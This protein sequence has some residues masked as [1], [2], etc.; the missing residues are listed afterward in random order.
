MKP[1]TPIPA[2]ELMRLLS[3]RLE[4]Q[5]NVAVVVRHGKEYLFV[6]YE[7]YDAESAT[8][9]CSAQKQPEVTIQELVNPIVY[10]NA[11]GA[12]Q[13]KL[14]MNDGTEMLVV[15]LSEKTGYAD[16]LG[17][18]NGVILNVQPVTTAV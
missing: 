12:K 1:I 5:Y 16:K 9:L 4:K 8:I 7:S 11:T 13:I 2:D 17:I 6:R 3:I 15:G 10:N 18:H 14:T